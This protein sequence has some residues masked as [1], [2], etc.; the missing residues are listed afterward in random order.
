M[1]IGI[2]SSFGA[3][4]RC[5]FQVRKISMGFITNFSV[6]GFGPVLSLSKGLS[7]DEEGWR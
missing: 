3:T 4:A 7:K 2:T 1:G 5:Y 6:E